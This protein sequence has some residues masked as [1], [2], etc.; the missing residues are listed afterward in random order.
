MT[1]PPLSCGS[2]GIEREAEPRRLARLGSREMV[3]V[4]V[5]VRQEF[6]QRALGPWTKYL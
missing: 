4:Y 3:R 2:F 5:D 6:Q 1:L